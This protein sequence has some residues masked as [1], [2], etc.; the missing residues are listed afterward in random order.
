MKMLLVLFVLQSF[1]FKN[2]V[3]AGSNEN[4]PTDSSLRYEAPDDCQWWVRGQGASAG[5]DEVAL[6]CNL[7]TINSEF[8]T[9]NFSVIPSE[10]TTS[11]RI[12]CNQ[13]I[14]SRSSLD[15]RSFVH[16]S[17]LRALEL[18]HCKLSRWPAGTLLGLRDLR[19]LTVRTHNT[20]WE[21]MNLEFSR[22]SFNPVRQLERLDLCCNNIW[23]FPESI[24]CPLIN[25][26]YLNVSRNRL[27]DVSDLG[28]REKTPGPQPLISV[29]EEEVPRSEE[30]NLTPPC[31]M[32]IQ[33]LDASFNHFVLLPANGFSV[34]KRLKELYI[35]NNEINTIADKALDGL[36]ALQT[37]DLSNN[38]LVALPIELF[39]DCRE[40]IREIYLQNNTITV[41]G[42]G[43]FGNLTQLLALDLSRNLLTISWINQDTFA[44]LIRLVLL[45]LSYN[46]IT[47]LD[48]DL[49]HDLYTLQILNLEHN[50]LETIPADTFAP[51][52]NLHT[53]IISYNRITYLDAYS[54]NGLYVLSLLALDNNILEGIHPEAFRNCSSLQDLNLNSNQLKAVP[55]ALKNMRLLRTLDLGE[56]LIT[57]LE[58]PGFRGLNNLYG[59]RMLGNRI[60]N[61]T[62]RAFADLPALQ[63]LNLARNRVQRVEHNSFSNSPN[64][65]AIRLDG[66]QLT[67][68]NGLFAD[69]KS[70]LWLNVS[71]NRLE[72]FDYALIPQGLQWLDLHKNNI[73]ELGNRFN[74]DDDL[75]LEQLDASFNK[76]TRITPSSFPS[77]IQ[78]LFL[79]DNLISL[80]EPHTFLQKTNLSRVDLYAN[81]ITHMD[82]NALRL[83]PVESGKQL[84]EFYIGGNPFQ[85]DCTMEW[86]QTINKLD[87]LHVGQRPRVMDLDSIYCKLLHNREVS[88][89]PLIHVESS[90]FLCTYK[91]HCFTVCRCCD[92]DACDC[93]MTCPNNCTCYPQSV[94]EFQC[95]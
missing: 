30:S 40:T 32:D 95:C 33:T 37:I 65:Q 5:Q 34:L 60:Q 86:L 1:I 48:H 47:H 88:Y 45:N 11:L 26:G 52:N 87:Q 62:K 49:F 50:A 38:K 24:F 44:G 74:L 43:L 19:N 66:N 58:E 85:C 56:N 3:F 12:E 73:R 18:E 36:K 42:P 16:L 89:M 77:S 92:F 21:K 15:D 82:S 4:V 10:H 8:D 20:D 94:M 90:Q 46:R 23:S 17:K 28:F 51:M 9:T 31:S 63:I 72:W 61:I 84:P 39:N 35:H 93:E 76:I 27:Q 70:L 54:L 79:N 57:Y 55:L 2:N 22:G 7:R 59:L 75:K 41:L 67:D 64:L 78:L 83:T 71:D 69:I 80:V 53:L 81:Q 91:T 29:T 14:L 25:L 13:D 6:T 68:V